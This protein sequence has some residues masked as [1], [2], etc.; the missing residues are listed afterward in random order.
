MV[1]AYSALVE[2]IARLSYE[3]VS[4][5]AKYAHKTPIDFSNT[6]SRMSKC[7]VFLKYE[8][9]QKTGAFKVRGALFKVS[10][11]A[12]KARGVVTASAGN[13]AQGVAYAA[14][15]HGLRAVIVMPETA[16]ISKVE[17]TRSY[18]AEVVLYGRVYD[19]AEEKA[20]AIAEEQGLVYVHAF[21][22]EEVIAGQ[23]TI[24]YELLEQL[25]SFDVVVV[26]IGGGGLAS[27]V[28]S[29]IKTRRP[30]VSIIG[31][32]PANAPKMV[33][34][35]RA[36]K[37]VTIEPKPTIADGLVAKRPGEL[38]YR[39]VSEL[40][41]DI[42]LVS[43]EE[44][45]YAIYMLLERAKVLAEGAGAAALAALLAG[46]VACEG[47]RVVALVTG[48]NIDLTT[49]YRVLLRGVASQ[50]RLAR[51]TGY[52]L[53]VPGEL[54]KILSVI[55]KYRGNVVDI[56]HDRSDAK[57]PAWHAK[58]SIVFEA[59]SRDTVETIVRELRSIGYVFTVDYPA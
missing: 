45:A 29:V 1:M 37:P 35:L 55:A 25:P 13:H 17:A 41:D 34:S 2:R 49:L 10:R 12:G 43:E 21:D 42:V 57:A 54:A 22:D 28:A 53:D 38:T 40:V 8:N 6:F 36:G 31:V 39:L 4:V 56:Y 16:S 50:G 19:E 11:V 20:Q 52:V 59:P 14:R 48:G 46:K 15:V 3:A 51:I 23:G 33:A 18:G 24:A 26:P 27:G 32:E 9:L 58:V 7:K 44:I 47:K 30:G 5:I